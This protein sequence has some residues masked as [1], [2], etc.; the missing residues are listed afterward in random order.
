[1]TKI[2]PKLYDSEWLKKTYETHTTRQMAE[3]AGCSQHGIMHA[4][5]RY[6][7]ETRPPDYRHFH[8]LKDSDWLT[9]QY[10]T[11]STAQIAKEVGCNIAVVQ[12]AIRKLGITREKR[13]KYPILQN[14]NWLRERYSQV[15]VSVIAKEVGCS[16]LTV[17]HALRDIG[18]TVRGRGSYRK[19]APLWDEEQLRELCKSKTNE[20]IAQFLNC[21]Y[22]GL[23]KALSRFGLTAQYRPK[24]RPLVK[25]R[26]AFVKT[27]DG[28]SIQES[29]YLMEQKLGRRLETTEHVHHI[30]GNPR[31]NSTDNLVVLNAKEHLKIHSTTTPY[32]CVKCGKTGFGGNRRKYCDDCRHKKPR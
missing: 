9:E 25:S 16:T 18:V 7:I 12:N 2:N 22:T 14:E 21:S 17:Y 11:K 1:M 3:L 20:E 30:D 8:Q 31:N 15:E 26:T 23:L 4:L 28:R 24:K 13:T 32:A 10:R 29:R 19:M 27:P 5:K 6:G